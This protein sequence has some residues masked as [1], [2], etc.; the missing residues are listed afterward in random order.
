MLIARLALRD[1]VR[2]RFFLICNVAV[3]VGVLVPLLVLFG[4]KNGVYSALIGEMLADPANLQIDTAGN[5]T[6]T[7]A[8]IAPLRDW[9]EIA[10]LTPK[11]RSQFD[12]MTI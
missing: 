3:M 2:D 5:A 6:L 4:V 8:D 1:L 12:Y 7:E 9:P 10:F 11:V